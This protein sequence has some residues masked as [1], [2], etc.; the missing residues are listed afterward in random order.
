MSAISD[1]PVVAYRLSVAGED[2]DYLESVGYDIHGNEQWAVR[3]NGM[4]LS[5]S[6]EWDREP[7]PSSSLRTVEWYR[8]HRF[9]S[10]E[11]G[12]MFWERYQTKIANDNR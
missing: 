2:P 3:S 9:T 11:E 10:P 4:C 5:R 1:L 7:M 6:L 12:L 8:Q